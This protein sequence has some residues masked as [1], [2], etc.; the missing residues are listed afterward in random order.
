[1][2][3]NIRLPIKV[4]ESSK[5]DFAK[6]KA[7]GASRKIFDGDDLKSARHKRAQELDSVERYFD[8]WFHKEPHIP[9]VAKVILKKD[10]LAKSHRP[11]GLFT[12][13]SCPIIGG[14]N[15]RELFISITRNDLQNL[16]DKILN[17]KNHN[18]KAN[19]STIEKIEPFTAKDAIGHIEAKDFQENGEIRFRLFTH[20]SPSVNRILIKKFISLVINL[21][22]PEPQEFSYANE[23][24]IFKISGVK[25]AHIDKLANFVGTQNLA[26]FPR[27]NLVKIASI[28]VGT[29]DPKYFK[30]PDPKFNY[31]VIGI[32]D[33]GTNPDDPILS[34]WVVKR[35]VYVPRNDIDYDHGSFVAGLAIHGRLLN[36]D[37][38]FPSTPVKFVDVTAI[39]KSNGITE[40]KLLTILEEVLPKHPEIKLWNLSLNINPVDDDTFSPIAMALDVLQDKHNVTFVISA[41]NYII[42]PVRGWPPEDLGEAD[43]IFSPAESVRGIAVGSLAHIDRPGARVKRGEPSPFSRRGPG[44]A[45][46]PKPELAH[47]GG[48]CKS[49]LDYTQIG[50]RS[51]NGQGNIAEW[52]GT[53]FSTPLVAAILANVEGNIRGNVT[54]CLIRALSV[55]SAVL[56]TPTL[57]PTE[58]KYKGFGTP[59]D[60]SSI[61]TCAPWEATLIFEPELIPGFTFDKHPFPIPQ[62][63]FRDNDKVTGEIIMT[64]A[65]DPPLDPSAGAEYCRI[66]VTASLGTC[67]LKEGKPY[68]HSVQIW[69]LPKNEELINLY[70]HYQIKHGFKWSPLKVY[71]RLMPRGVKGNIWNLKLRILARHDYK[72]TKPKPQKVALVVTMR[73]PNK[74]APVY[75]Q[76][77][78]KMRQIGWI[79]QDLQV[80]ER[81]RV[82]A[83]FTS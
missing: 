28:P 32:V 16:I 18:A 47:Y 23:M 8:H 51:L 13:Q 58:L 12:R 37:K 10:A 44:A 66:N 69:P 61:L 7:G 75:D 11:S 50:I 40:D 38:R 2:D 19:I 70:E 20:N 80:E 62:S 6:P 57:T 25:P 72:F 14:R 3:K 43:R 74:T 1:M 24:K 65:Y 4:V 71:R 21:E 81:I 55:H 49:D 15:F 68:E 22:L 29:A 31:P 5:K 46:L 63:L 42:P 30:K 82:S 39:P 67:E 79:T 48:N 34:P 27:F 52:I 26:T 53:S 36:N 73:D 56:N 54:P 9:A 33:T 83:G 60:L 64:L 78:A 41:G 17:E 59:D 77:V 45:F 35:Y 76:T